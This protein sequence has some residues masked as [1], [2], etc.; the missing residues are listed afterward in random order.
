MIGLSRLIQAGSDMHGRLR[1]LV[2]P[3]SEGAGPRDNLCNRPATAAAPREI[4][5]VGSQ[6]ERCRQSVSAWGVRV[7]SDRCNRSWRQKKMLQVPSCRL[8]RGKKEGGE[9]PSQV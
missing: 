5:Q 7:K 1:R 9:V 3:S 8:G 2:E 6:C 4:V